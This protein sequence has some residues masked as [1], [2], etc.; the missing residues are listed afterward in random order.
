VIVAVLCLREWKLL[1]IALGP[2]S[3][4]LAFS[5]KLGH[6]ARS[7]V[8]GLK[9]KQINVTCKTFVL[10]FVELQMLL[11]RKIQL[12]GFIVPGT[13]TVHCHN[14]VGNLKTNQ[15]LSCFLNKSVNGGIVDV[16]A[17]LF[18]VWCKCTS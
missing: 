12:L 8:E 7:A 5:L 13:E 17:G 9:E 14:V 15:A 2:W 6:T 10:C 4:L 16:K 18:G 11:E 3:L 1:N